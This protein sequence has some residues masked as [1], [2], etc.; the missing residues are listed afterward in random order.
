[1]VLFF[2]NVNVAQD[3][4]SAQ[5]LNNGIKLSIS[6]RYE[7]A[8][9]AFQ[10]IIKNT[11]N[12]GDA[13][14]YYGENVLN[15]YLADPYSSTL[16]DACTSARDIFQ[17]GLR[18]DSLN[19]LNAIGLG[20][21]ILMEK[22]DT[23]AA[24]VYFNKAE[25]V[26]PKNKKKYTEKNILMLVKLGTAQ[27]FAKSPRYKKAIAYLERAKEVAPNNPDVANGLGDVHMS[28][29][30]ASSAI[31]NYNRAL[32]LNPSSPV[33]QVKI[34]NIYMWARNLPE[35]SNYFE[36]AKAIDSTFAP[37]YKGFGA[38]Y[39]MGG[40]YKLS[41][42]NY[43]KFLT[44]SGNNT[45]AKI[46]YANSLYRSKDFDAALT[47]ID[48]IL[49]VDK[50][51]PYLYRLAGYSSFDK[52]PA[53]FPRALGYL[54]TLF[55]NMPP[56]KIIL[57]DYMYYGKTLINLKR[58]T[59]QIDKGLTMLLKAYQMDTTDNELLSNITTSAQTMKR[60]KIATELL[61]KIIIQ[62]K[63]TSNDYMNLGKIY[64]Q[65]K[66]FGKADTI[67]TKLTQKEPNNVQAYLW[68]ANTYFNMDP[69]SKLGIAKP[70]YDKVV[71]KALTDTAKYAQELYS[72][73]SYLGS[74]YL[75]G[76]K[77][78]IDNAIKYFQ[79]II[80]LNTNNKQWLV[81][82]YFSLGI[83]YSDKRK[84]EYEKA[85]EYYKKVLEIDPNNNNKDVI[86]KNI[87]DINKILKS[88]QQ[89]Q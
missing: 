80:K 76:A 83:A 85:L 87:E 39:Y 26:F 45:S 25:S 28:R 71:E 44:L 82:A 43:K 35:A 37:L 89:Q 81:N 11:P 8:N 32:Y 62:G 10:Q 3:L 59:V 30:D 75:F 47:V 4:N 49:S 41:K 9:T 36:K 22:N 48:E 77:P 50:S 73:Y 57:K 61:N 74:Y 56:D 70:K 54:E 2:V 55:K 6:E 66:Q 52:K 51:R 17:K 60:Y 21:V 31:S 34:G 33:Y 58:D 84:K 68:I 18:A 88:R 63:A 64:Y 27:L 20:A 16:S 12:N 14:F 86:K 15:S 79:K 23:T 7:D 40:K 78:E 38:M 72:A 42:D 69:D 67:F 24:D 53:D 46:S 29:N 5:D 13:Y 1:M 65:T 19:M